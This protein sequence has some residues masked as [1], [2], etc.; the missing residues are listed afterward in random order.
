MKR[1]T[2][3]KLCYFLYLCDCLNFTFGRYGKTE[4]KQR[5]AREFSKKNEKNFLQRLIAMMRW[6]KI[7]CGTAL[8][9]CQFRKLA[10]D[11]AAI[12]LVTLF[13][14]SLER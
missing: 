10:N 5:Y 4:K 3:H 9:K 13:A 11:F 14:F 12:K 2:V 8:R 6:Q 7:N 1:P